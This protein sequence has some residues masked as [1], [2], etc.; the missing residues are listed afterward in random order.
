MIIFFA[1]GRLG[2]QVFQYSFLRTIAKENET[3]VCF[4]MEMFYRTFDFDNHHIRYV[5]NWHIDQFCKKIVLPLIIK[6]SIKLGLINYIEQKKDNNLYPLLEWSEKKGILRF[7]RYVNTDFFQSETF[8]DRNL[9][10]DLKIK[11]KYTVEARNF[12]SSISDDYEKVFIHVRRGDYLIQVFDGEQGINLPKSYFEKAIQSIKNTVKNPF[13]ILLSDDPSFV[14][15]WFQD[16]KPKLISENSMEVDLAIM[17][18][19]EAGIIS[20]SSFS[21]WG[22]YLMNTRKKVIAPKFWYGWKKRRESHR[23]IQPSFSEVIDFSE[24][25][26]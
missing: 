7:L 16:L 9:I 4:N 6:P 26:E 2:N 11:E 1:D 8:F 21:W 18:L 10:S 17:A 12:I 20:N 15:E 3:I 25:H 19:C 22:A 13:F 24:S 23:G 14:K 5:S